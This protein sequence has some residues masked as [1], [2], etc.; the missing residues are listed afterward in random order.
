MQKTQTTLGSIRL[1]GIQERTNNLSEMN[2]LSAKILKTVTQYHS[3]EYGHKIEGRISHPRRIFCC[4]T[5]YE[6]DFMGDYT[7]FIGEEASAL[8][9]CPKDMSELLIQHQDYSKFTTNKGPMPLVV[10]NAWQQIW[11]M[12]D[13]HLGGTRNYQTDFE[14]Y[15][16]DFNPGSASVEI[17]IGLKDAL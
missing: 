16:E 11:T 15:N 14:I 17:Y 13:E 9:T 6:S 4:Y 7:F 8:A 10:I 3:G 1:F 12:S 2:P 5:E